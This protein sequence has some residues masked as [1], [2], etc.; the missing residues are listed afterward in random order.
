MRV[1]TKSKH[2]FSDGEEN[3]FTSF[4]A[5]GVSAHAFA[6]YSVSR[7]YRN[8]SATRSGW[9]STR[10][11]YGQWRPHSS[12]GHLCVTLAPRLY[13]PVRLNSMHSSASVCAYL[14][15]SPGYMGFT[16]GM[17]TPHT[18]LSLPPATRNSFPYCRI[19]ITGIYS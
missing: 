10:C 1:F 17:S 13:R 8:S 7:P 4:D 16:V 6:S 5:H 18:H 12:F 15:S 11:R 19:T 3:G 2:T 14:F 9:L